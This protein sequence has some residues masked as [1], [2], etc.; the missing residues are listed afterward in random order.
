M[1]CCTQLQQFWSDPHKAGQTDMK[2]VRLTLLDRL[3]LCGRNDSGIVGIAKLLESLTENPGAILT[4]SSPEC[5]KRFFSQ[6]QLSVWTL[7]Q[8]P[9]LYSPHVQPHTPTEVHTIKI[10]NTGSHTIVWDIRK[11]CTYW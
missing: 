1:G 9:Q 11:Y 2:L 10:P 5:G 3:T 7:L 8:C 4:G 6:S